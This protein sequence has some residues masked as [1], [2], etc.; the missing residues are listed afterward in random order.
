MSI[1]FESKQNL[2]SGSHAIV[3]GGSMAGLLAARMLVNSFDR[4]TLVERDLFPEQ[5][6]PRPGV[7][8]ASHVH[9]LLAQGQRILQQFFPG[10]ETDLTAKGAVPVDWIGDWMTYWMWGWAP[11]FQSGLRGYACSRYLLEWIIRHRLADYNNLKLLDG[12]QVTQLLTNETKSQVTGV[13]LR[14]RMEAETPLEEELAADLV[15]DASGRNSSMPKWLES[16]GYPPVK[17]TVIDSF[18]GYG[19]R[20]YRRKSGFSADW[21]GLTVMGKPPDNPRGG[22]LYPV[23][24]DRWVVTLGGSGHDYPPTDEEG[25]LEFARSL[26]HP[27]IYET[28]KDAE[29]LSPVYSYRRTANRL[30]HYDQLS[31]LPEGVVMIGDAVCA[32]NPIY[33]QG[34]TTAALGALTLDDCLRE[35]FKTTKHSLT[36]LTRRF[37]KRLAKVNSTPWMMATGEDLRWPTTSGGQIDKM[38]L[39]MQGYMDRVMEFSTNHPE[40]YQTFGEV[41]HLVKPPT[42]LFS[43]RILAPVL[44]QGMGS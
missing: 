30:R 20:W 42:A 29:P 32:F 37:Q 28:I 15:V 4:V 27:I 23:E 2:N 39:L 8:Q 25:F 13:Q 12:V 11:R 36:G 21:Q 6:E 24:C 38:S 7:P 19:S 43:P 40:V 14:W 1:T 34:M 44:L 10:I 22:V 16:W 9:V 41:A 17:E 26:R 3:I 35:Q 33:G 18:L 5:P 31:N